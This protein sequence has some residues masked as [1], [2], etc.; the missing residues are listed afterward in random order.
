MSTE[1]LPEGL[2][3][4]FRQCDATRSDLLLILGP[5]NRREWTFRR[6]VAS[7][8]VAECVDHLIRAEI[9]T[10][11]MVR[12]L[13]RGDFS[14]TVRPRE[15][16]LYDSSLKKYPYGRFPAPSGLVPV[17]QPKN[18]T[19]AQLDVVHRRFAEELS[20]FKGGDVDALASED[21]DTG[22]WFTLGGWVRLQALHEA[23]H[24]RTIRA[25]LATQ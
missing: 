12:R 5:V 13:I 7:W 1:G 17:P 2:R 22:L 6:D 14:G 8:T 20:R 23:H 21:Q 11:K 10:S 9:G 16:R 15:A 25:L 18:K 3:A 24:I 19:L 4:P